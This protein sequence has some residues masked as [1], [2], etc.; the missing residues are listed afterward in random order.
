VSEFL[1]LGKSLDGMSAL[2]TGASSGIGWATAELLA[3][4]GARVTLVAR[5]ANR[6]E[7]L[8]DRIVSAGGEAI[9]IPADITDQE[10]A[11]S[12]VERGTGHWN[13]LDI[14]VNNAGLL[15]A[16]PTESAPVEEFD[17]MIDVNV[18][19]L[20]YVSRAAL[21]PL[22]AA[23]ETSPR[24]VSDLVNVSSVSGRRANAGSAVYNASKFAV[25]GFSECLRMEVARRHVRV[26]VIEPGSV[27][28]ELPGQ[29]RQE[30][31]DTPN[32]DFS[33]FTYLEA[34]DVAET[35]AFTVTRSRR[36]CVSELM[37]RP[38]EQLV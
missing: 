20:L 26:S 1:A 2:V 25:T 9:T 21:A 28:T 3:G 5:R 7:E 10:Q 27:V 8:A 24:R 12:C 37:V 36:V 19:G 11:Q 14:V 38:T 13:R 16:G 15:L 32:P 4:L 30:V 31:R 6:I 22:L 18:R 17:R 29:M 34:E 35:I 23:A 33:G